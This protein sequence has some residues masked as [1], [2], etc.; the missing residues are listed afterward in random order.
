[1][2]EQNADIREAIKASGIK[3]YE[4]AHELGISDGWF[5]KLLRFELP[6]EKKNEIFNAI[7]QLK[8]EN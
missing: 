5:S 3:K 8:A 6:T 7:E 1:M 4:I 2:R